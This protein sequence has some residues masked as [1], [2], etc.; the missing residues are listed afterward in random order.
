MALI[1]TQCSTAPAPETAAPEIPR[2][3]Q[4]GTAT[5]LI[6]DGE[7][8]LMI[9][10]ELHNSSSSNLE[11]MAPIW[12]KL[13]RMNLNTV[14]TALSWELVE[15]EEGQFDYSLV[16]GLIEG[17]REEDLKIVFLWFGSWKNGKSS[18]VPG[19]V[20]KD[21]ER[22]PRVQIQDG[23]SVEILSTFSEESRDADARAFA[24]L[25]RHIKEVDGV[26]QTV[27]MMQVE[28]EVG[29]RGDSRDRCE[30]ANEAFTAPVPQELM[31]YIQK[32][33]DNMIPELR[34]M[35][36]SRGFPASGS[37]EEVF[38][39]GPAVDEAFMAWQYAKYID[40]VTAAG[41]AEYDL[42]MFVNAWL[43]GPTTNPGDWPSG[44]PLP[45]V[46]DMWK[47]AGTHIDMVTPD[48]YA[49]NFAD[50]CQWYRQLGNPLLIPETRGGAA[51]A[52]NVFYA[53]G[54]HD[55]M[56]FSPFAIDTADMWEGSW[57]ERREDVE[58]FGLSK[59]YAALEQ[60]RPLILE[61]QGSDQ[62]TGMLLENGAKEASVELGD[63][64]FN[65]VAG[66][67]PFEPPPEPTSMFPGMPP[68]HPRAGAIFISLGPDEFLAAGSGSFTVTFSPHTPGPPNAGI[69]SVD[70]GRFVDG[71]WV[72]CRKLNGDP[73]GQGERLSFS[74]FFESEENPIKRVKL[75]R[76]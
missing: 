69:L 32:N 19:W 54:R 12:P 6:V 60:L 75:Y 34:K 56:A 21:V 53:M 2:L 4:Q 13:A 17:A 30:A 31:D 38:G 41:K 74:R 52:A 65:V 23:Q 26:E 59:A 24:A 55:A 44:G 11:Y 15:P 58:N 57:E 43:S 70:E 1:A 25:M 63:Y 50:W 40:H 47:A 28:N 36:E 76:Y 9:A 66:G 10:G 27:I 22:F 33:R 7:P 5:Q 45:H 46:M 49:A 29:V 61:N 3:Q 67:S 39:T 64:T 51:G 73:T 14:L 68:E 42:P 71:E 62:M 72:A 35:W 18:Y 20:K 8:W 37:W 16:D 48:I